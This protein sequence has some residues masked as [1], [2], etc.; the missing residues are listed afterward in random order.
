MVMMVGMITPL[1][2][3]VIMMVVA[4]VVVGVVMIMV[5]MGVVIVRGGGMRDEMKEGVAQ[6]TA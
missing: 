3:V 1:M 6:Q 2:V 4:M 5:I